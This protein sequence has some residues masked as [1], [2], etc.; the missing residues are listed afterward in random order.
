MEFHDDS[1][2]QQLKA[3]MIG[4][5]SRGVVRRTFTRVS[6][7][8]RITAAKEDLNQALQKFVVS[9]ICM[10]VTTVSENNDKIAVHNVQLRSQRRIELQLCT[11]SRKV[12]F[13]QA[14]NVCS[15]ECQEYQILKM[16]QLDVHV[17]RGMNEVGLIYSRILHT[18]RR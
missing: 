12:D 13:V 16:N 18:I 10:I 4:H 8:K 5:A 2:L 6:D 1:T 11:L 7:K 3:L 14:Q 17:R 15:S 9:M